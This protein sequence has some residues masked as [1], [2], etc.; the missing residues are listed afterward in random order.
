MSLPQQNLR[1][2]VNPTQAFQHTFLV[3][4]LCHLVV[5]VHGTVYLIINKNNIFQ[6]TNKQL[7]KQLYL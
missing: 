6:Q 7:N 2:P 4:K 5:T 3:C 1:G